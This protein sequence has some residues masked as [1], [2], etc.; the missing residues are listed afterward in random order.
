MDYVMGSVNA[1]AALD[2]G[3]PVG[4][5][6]DDDIDLGVLPDLLGYNLRSAQLALQRGLAK[7]IPGGDPGSGIFGLLVLCAG[8]PGISQIQVARHLTIDKA[9]VVALVDRG[10]ESGWLLR[11]RA[12]DDR[13][14][15]GLFITSDG[16]AHLDQMKARMRACEQSFDALFEPE[17]R[18]QL[19]SL[20]QRIRP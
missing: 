7:A 17:E 18:R 1:V 4:A 6:A 12:P 19:L 3:S 10:E 15:H 13:R 16:Q 11:R 8:N 14:R 9:S 5:L 2:M 20:L